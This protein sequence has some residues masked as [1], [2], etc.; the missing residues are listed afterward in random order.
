MP[1]CKWLCSRFV[2]NWMKTEDLAITSPTAWLLF[3]K[4][5]EKPENRR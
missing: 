5:P 2:N 3:V 1:H 4:N